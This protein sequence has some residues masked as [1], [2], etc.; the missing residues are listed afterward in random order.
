MGFTDASKMFYTIKNVS[1]N[2]LCT[3]LRNRASER[4]ESDEEKVVKS[5]PTIYFDTSW[6]YR[7]V[8]AA[9]SIKTA[10][11]VVGIATQ[12][13]KQN[14]NVVLANDNKSSRHHSKKASIVRDQ[15]SEQSRIDT[16][17]LKKQLLSMA[18][19]IRNPTISI[20]IQS[21]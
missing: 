20:S 1:F 12:F 14:I 8:S 16:I 9:D 15:R 5:G 19:S 18:S 13:S 4:C 11:N 7:K 21:I 10:S 3:I 2:D 6:L 17:Y